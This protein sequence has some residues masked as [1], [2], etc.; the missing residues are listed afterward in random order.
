MSKKCREI[1]AA[2][3]EEMTRVLTELH[4]AMKTYHLFYAECTVMQAKM[5]FAEQ[6]KTKFETNN[7][8][9]VREL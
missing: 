6:H 8:S 7:P 2:S 3:H 1:G 5:N 9:K 4:T